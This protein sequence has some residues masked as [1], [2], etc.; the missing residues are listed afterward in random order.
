MVSRAASL[1]E[2]LVGRPDAWGDVVARYREPVR[3]H[4]TLEHVEEVLA[5]LGD[6]GVDDPAALLA[7]VLHDVVYDPTRSDNEEAS[8][9]YASRALAHL[10]PAVVSRTCELVL[11]TKAHDACGA[12]DRPCAALLDADLAI[13]AAPAER[14]DRYAAAIR[15]E[16]AHVPEEVFRSGRREVLEGFLRRDRLFLTDTLHGRLDAPA[17][18]N[19]CRELTRLH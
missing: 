18:A 2:A 12:G 16:Y 4:H 3:A 10:D 7:A 1:W 17:R 8:A 9:R 13:L 5:T 15:R 14:Y 19:L 11:A 6:L